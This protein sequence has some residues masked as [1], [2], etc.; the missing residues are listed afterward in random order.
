MKQVVFEQ[1]MAVI[2]TL[3]VKT[4]QSLVR[5]FIAVIQERLT[6][7]DLVIIP[8]FGLFYAAVRAPKN[9]YNPF[10]ESVIFYGTSNVVKFHQYYY[11]GKVLDPT[12]KSY[13][14]V[15]STYEYPESDLALR[16]SELAA[17]DILICNQFVYALVDEMVRLINDGDTVTFNNLGTF[18]YYWLNDKSYKNPR[19]GLPDAYGARRKIRF[20][21]SRLLKEL[22]N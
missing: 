21:C 5:A 10:Y 16:I 8:R 15:K 13:I 18:N 19:T 20:K 9:I 4:I 22:V 6:V 14:T 12:W 2:M 7:G 11:A 17:I 3:P 1:N